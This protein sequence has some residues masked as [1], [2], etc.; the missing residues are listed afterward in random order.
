VKTPGSVRPSLFLLRFVKLE[1]CDDQL[2]SSWERS[3]KLPC[4]RSTEWAQAAVTG[5]TVTMMLV[6][7]LVERDSTGGIKM[8][9]KG[10]RCSKS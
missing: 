1:C 10:G 4:G 7:G 8:T 2:H 5:A 6:R 9:P 3:H